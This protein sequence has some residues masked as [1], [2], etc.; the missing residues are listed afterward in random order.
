MISYT[1]EVPFKNN[2]ILKYLVDGWFTSGVISFQSGTP[3]TGGYDQNG[4]GEGYNDRPNWGNPKAP[5]NYSA[6]C[7]SNP[8]CISGVGQDDG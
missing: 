2:G 4:D 3:E 5:L 7:M 8:T 6:S 1:Y